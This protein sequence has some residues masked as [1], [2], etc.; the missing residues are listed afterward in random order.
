M[1][2]NACTQIP[3]AVAAN[4]ARSGRRPPG[5]RVADAS[6]RV[7]GS[8]CRPAHAA[9]RT[10]VCS[11]PSQPDS[12]SPERHD[13]R[14]DA[15][16]AAPHFIADRARRRVPPGRRDRV[17]HRRGRDSPL[18]VRRH[19]S[20]VEAG[21]QCADGPGGAAGRTHRHARMERVP[22]PGALLRRVGYGR[23]AAHGQPAA[24][25]GPDRVHRQSRRGQLPVLRRSRSRR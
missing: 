24:V 11:R 16:S 18:H 15:G 25:P 12:E 8:R 17:A 1:G 4:A 22:A 23:R 5:A 14:T 21:G 10:I 13:A 3:A 9:E 2:R 19:S 7:G 20:P 6:G